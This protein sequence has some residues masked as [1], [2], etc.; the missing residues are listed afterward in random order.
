MIEDTLGFDMKLKNPEGQRGMFGIKQ[1]FIGGKR[2]QSRENLHAHIG[3]HLA[4][5][6]LTSARFRLQVEEKWFYKR[7]V[8]LQILS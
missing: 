4:A 1:T 8:N 2:D 5:F 3:V 7:I 6:P